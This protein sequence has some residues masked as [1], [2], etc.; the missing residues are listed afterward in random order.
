M[1]WIEAGGIVRRDIPDMRGAGA[2]RVST[3]MVRGWSRC[4]T[5]AGVPGWCRC[6]VGDETVVRYSKVGI[7]LYLWYMYVLLYMYRLYVPRSY[8][9]MK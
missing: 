7:L 6:C 4:A 9:R 5:R 3:T 8:V 2:S 1:A